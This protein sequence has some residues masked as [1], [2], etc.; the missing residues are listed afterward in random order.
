MI[1]LLKSKM[2]TKDGRISELTDQ[3]LNLSDTNLKL[4]ARLYSRQKSRLCSA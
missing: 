3:N 4:I 1:D 2:K